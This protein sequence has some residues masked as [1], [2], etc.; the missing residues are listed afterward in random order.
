MTPKFRETVLKLSGLPPARVVFSEAKTLQVRDIDIGV[1]VIFATWSG[2]SHVGWREVS[3]IFATHAALQ[4]PVHI[5]DAD[6][7]TSE[8]VHQLP[9][10]PLGNGESYWIRAEKIVHAW[11]LKS[12]PLG[13]IDRF[14]QEAFR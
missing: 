12:G 14:T 8:F 10:V 2:P 11:S 3:R 7:L 1:F 13:D 5:V 9:L 6:E 4:F